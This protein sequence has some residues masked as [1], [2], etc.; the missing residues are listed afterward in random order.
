MISSTTSMEKPKCF[1]FA[2]II[3]APLLHLPVSSMEKESWTKLKKPESPKFNVSSMTNQQ[4]STPLKIM[5]SKK[6]PKCLLLA[7]LEIYLWFTTQDMAAMFQISTVINK[8]DKM[9]L[10]ASDHRKA[11]INSLP[12]MKRPNAYLKIYQITSLAF[13]L[14]THA[15]QDQFSTYPKT[16]F[17]E[18]KKYTA[19][20]DVKI[21]SIP[22][23][24]VMEDKWQTSC[25]LSS[26]KINI[27]EPQNNS[28]FNTFSTEWFLKIKKL[29]ETMQD[30][31]RFK[32]MHNFKSL[33]VLPFLVCVSAQYNF[34][35]KT[36]ISCQMT[37][38]SRWLKLLWIMMINPDNFN[39][40]KSKQDQANG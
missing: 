3:K 13:L 20:Q 9:K 21:I 35:W 15:I 36:R 32:H 2:S 23:I 8:T 4:I 19:Y 28:Q 37:I 40:Q 25:L 5:S 39:Q 16:N 33:Q 34:V 24:Q 17:G 30:K 18:I 7:Q 26:D 1:S 10:S 31:K 29:K 14:L 6:W 11:N 38:F 27:K 12:M 22:T